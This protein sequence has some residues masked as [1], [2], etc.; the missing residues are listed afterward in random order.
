[1]KGG[2]SLV[3]KLFLDAG[4]GGTDGGAQGNG[5]SEKD[6]NLSLVK[7][8]QAKIEK[9][10]KNVQ[11]MTTRTTDVF[12]TLK[13]RTDKANEW[14]A[15]Y[16]VSCHTN[17]TTS[18]SA[19]GFSSYIYTR[20][21]DKTKAFQNVMHEE[22]VKAISANTGVVNL[23]KKQA[24]FHVLRESHMTAILTENL[25]VSNTA[26]SALLKQDTFLDRLADGHVLGLEKFIG[27]EKNI[28]PPVNEP[29]QMYQVIAGTFEDLQN[30]EA[31]AEKLGK[32]GYKSYISKK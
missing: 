28:P 3:I 11:I 21:D 30:A 1:L 23:G 19:R 25:F 8:I 24:N 31:F 6:L 15:H 2:Q 13:E 16:F 17:S 12:L 29:K 26:D 5:L 14:G 22:I 7:K 9:G 27:L 4:H 10:Y 20:T 18:P 32:S